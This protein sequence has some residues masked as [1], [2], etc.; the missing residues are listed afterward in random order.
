MGFERIYTYSNTPPTHRY[1]GD[2]TTTKKERH[3]SADDIE[4]TCT[5]LKK[6]DRV[7]A[8][9]KLSDRKDYPGTV[10]RVVDK[11]HVSIHYDDDTQKKRCP[12]NCTMPEK[13][14]TFDPSTAQ[15]GQTVRVYERVIHLTF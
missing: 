10:T 2:Y 15:F 14:Q 12:L 3:V 7:R 4:V 1:Y 13:R 8:L 5:S 6:G 11:D 9:W